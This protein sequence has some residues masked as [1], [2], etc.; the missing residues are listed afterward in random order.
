MLLE[1]VE[2]STKCQMEDGLA[3]WI[4]R[5]LNFFHS[6][7]QSRVNIARIGQHE[8]LSIICGP[9]KK[10]HPNLLVYDLEVIHG[11]ALSIP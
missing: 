5:N 11:I 10:Y 2:V 1:A 9:L 6:F 7:N 8:L 3:G 4:R